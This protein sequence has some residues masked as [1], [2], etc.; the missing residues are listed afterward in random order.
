MMTDVQPT[1]A[2][3]PAAAMFPLLDDEELAELAADIADNG[4]RLPITLD[5]DGVLLDGRNRLRGCRLAEV[6]P[7]FTVYDGDPVAVILSA[8]IAR[9]HLSKGQRAMLVAKVAD[10]QNKSPSGK[11]LAAMIEVSTATISQ[12]NVVRREAGDLVEDVING[13]LSLTDA[14]VEALK[15]KRDREPDDAASDAVPD[16][17]ALLAA[18]D[19]SE[20]DPVIQKIDASDRAHATLAD[21]QR[22]IDAAWYVRDES[23]ETLYRAWCDLRPQPLTPLS[24]DLDRLARLFSALAEQVAACERSRFRIVGGD[25]S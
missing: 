2:V 19:A 23:G 11:T 14:Y 3:H 24:Q 9:R 21:L 22:V 8:N 25:E 12:A 20:S 13:D 10:L 5:P 7:T 4:L 15:R 6:E 17:G 1:G 18:L 16:R